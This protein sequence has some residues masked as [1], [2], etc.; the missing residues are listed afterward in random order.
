MNAA[1]IDCTSLISTFKLYISESLLSLEFNMNSAAWQ[2][3]FSLESFTFLFYANFMQQLK[4]V[5][6]FAFTAPLSSSLTHALFI[7]LT[8]SPTSCLLISNIQASLRFKLSPDSTSPKALLKAS[9]HFSCAMSGSDKDIAFITSHAG[10]LKLHWLYF[11][12]NIW[13]TFSLH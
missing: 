13:I 8:L 6:G 3:Q 9:K 7:T 10:P 5:R 1:N 4:E 11:N 12:R 2:V